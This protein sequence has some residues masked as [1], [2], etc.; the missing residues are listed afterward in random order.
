VDFS[1]GEISKACPDPCRV[2]LAKDRPAKSLTGFFFGTGGIARCFQAE[3]A[4][5]LAEPECGELS[6]SASRGSG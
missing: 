4:S 3:Y 5:G 2:C 1:Q 6:E